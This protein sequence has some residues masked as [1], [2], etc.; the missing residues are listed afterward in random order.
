[1]KNI[2]TFSKLFTSLILACCFA[3]TSTTALAGKGGESGG[4]GGNSGVEIAKSLKSVPKGMDHFHQLLWMFQNGSKPKPRYIESYNTCTEV[5]HGFEGAFDVDADRN[6]TLKIE[7]TFDSQKYCGS[8]IALGISMFGD[9]TEARAIDLR[10]LKPIAY[11][12]M[13]TKSEYQEYYQQQR[14][15]YENQLVN[16]FENFFKK[17]RCGTP[18]TNDP[19]RYPTITCPADFKVQIIEY[20]SLAEILHDDTNQT[21]AQYRVLDETEQGYLYP[22]YATMSDGLFGHIRRK[23]EIRSY[24][25]LLVGVDRADQNESIENQCGD[26]FD[27]GVLSPRGTVAVDGVCRIFYFTEKEVSKE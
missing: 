17:K 21:G 15:L 25:G 5:S 19:G 2:Q 22:Y 4:G 10:D 14:E 12:R 3:T 9:F 8:G 23:I 11:E 18:A 26:V 13:G 20:P 24:G 6:R 7:R 1:V 27:P 16:P